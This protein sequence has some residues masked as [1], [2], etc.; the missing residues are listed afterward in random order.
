MKASMILIL[1]VTLI[2][3]HLHGFSQFNRFFLFHEFI[4]CQV[5]FIIHKNAATMLNHDVET[6]RICSPPE[7]SL[8]NLGRWND[9][10]WLLP[11][12][13]N[14][15]AC[16]RR[17]FSYI[18]AWMFNEITYAHSPRLRLCTL[19]LMHIRECVSRGGGHKISRLHDLNFEGIR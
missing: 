16:I 18:C 7:K 6:N 14:A 17:I 11:R 9:F 2:I 12:K 19:S 3:V 10:F 15:R 1:F 4:Y 5:W 8:P 13:T